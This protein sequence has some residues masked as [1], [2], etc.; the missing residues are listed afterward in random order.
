MIKKIVVDGNDGTGKTCTI[1]RL[2]ELFPGIE[3]EDRGIFSKAT[4]NDDIFEE[5]ANHSETAGCL[6]NK[7]GQPNHAS[8]DFFREI[9]RNHDTFY[10]ICV[11]DPKECQRRIAER[12]DSIEEEFH[13]I[14]DLEK[15]DKR[16]RIL[17]DITSRLGN[18]MLV[19]TTNRKQI[20]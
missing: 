16:F 18:V 17:C 13:R 5:Y 20:V 4:L 6:Q 3:F 14:E 1:N 19:D 9:E 15:Y 11:A 7:N 10:I 8:F 2:K 12:G